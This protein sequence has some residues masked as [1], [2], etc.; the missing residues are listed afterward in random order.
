MQ[1][2]SAARV[3]RFFYSEW[4]QELLYTVIKVPG[5]MG[6]ENSRPVD[7]LEELQKASHAFDYAAIT[8]VWEEKGLLHNSK[9][10][11][12]PKKGTKGPLLL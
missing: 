12:R 7:L 4:T 6:L 8:E 9:Y 2:V 11:F 5:A 1:L 3:G 10:A